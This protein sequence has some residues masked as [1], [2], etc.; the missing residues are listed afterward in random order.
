VSC[1]NPKAKPRS[2]NKV[3]MVKAPKLNDN[4]T[5]QDLSASMDNFEEHFEHAIMAPRVGSCKDALIGIHFIEHYLLNKL[6]KD[7]LKI[8]T[9]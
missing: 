2:N 3:P 9:K 5:K 6:P 1:I 7:Q 8:A 4:P